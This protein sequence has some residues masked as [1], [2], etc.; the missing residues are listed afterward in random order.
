MRI[1]IK[2][3]LI[4]STIFI[5]SIVAVFV[6]ATS[7]GSLS[8][9][10]LLSRLGVASRETD[11]LKG[12][13]LEIAN[14]W[15]FLTDASLTQD[16]SVIDN[17]ATGSRN[18]AESF[19]SELLELN[20]NNTD[21]VSDVRK[22]LRYFWDIGVRM[23]V[24]YKSS[25]EEGDIYMDLFDESGEGL[26]SS[27]DMLSKPIIDYRNELVQDYQNG[28]QLISSILLGAGILIII[29]V[30]IL[31]FILIGQITRPINK[32]TES[33]EQLATSQ[34]D[35][36]TNLEVR[37][38]DELRGMATWFNEFVKKLRLILTNVSELIIK[39]EKIGTHL[40]TAS[41]NSALFISKIVHS[42]QDMRSG[43]EQLDSSIFSASSSA[44]EIQQTVL[45]LSRQVDHQF[46]AI[47]QSSTAT[48]EI[49]ASVANVAKISESRLST[50]DTLVDLI[51]NGGEKVEETNYIIQEIQRNADD[52]MNMIDII[53]DISN[54]TNLL[55][56]NASIEAAHAGEAGKGFAVVADEIRKLAEGTST[57]AGM[58]AQSL[59]STK[60]K[61]DEAKDAGNESEKA[62]DVINGEVAVFSGSLKEVSLSMNELSEASN[63]ILESISTLMDTSHVVKEASGELNVGIGEIL[64]SILQVKEV[65]AVTLQTVI[66]VSEFSEQL[67]KVSLQVSAFGNQ[68]KYNN[69]LLT[70]EIKK[71]HIGAEKRSDADDV[72]IGID[73][74]DLLSVGID[75][76]DDEHKELFT[77]INKLLSALLGGSDDYSIVEIISFINEY[78]DFHF[79]D[80]ENMLAKYNYPKL[81]EHKKLH[82]IYENE[83]SAIEKQLSQGQFDASL[84]IEIQD[85]VVNWL[86]DHIAVADKAYGVYIK[87]LDN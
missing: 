44:E 25:S 81:A 7:I 26:I 66:N 32:M 34:G 78:V 83:F 61:I 10:K 11:L 30:I 60:E 13:Q 46:S 82:A 23:Q 2:V 8:N 1:T 42:M 16:L 5:S 71:F 35:L 56:M 58:I 49:M 18:N 33:L 19:L 9:M 12:I 6:I 79:R 31:G 69:T 45:N 68:N 4:L 50:M 24:A 55:A 85:K 87:N 47:E 53:N 39:N 77:R 84:L 59:N 28:V 63:E 86:L 75:K 73:W 36:T 14:T 40:S 48:E 51:K 22:A 29:F 65:S 27:L 21:L 62:F 70:G 17:E 38:N 54:Q 52:M 67:N 37:A 80:E 57:N 64:N 76:M 72:S 74:S 20:N 3:K 43:S 41:K 15:Q